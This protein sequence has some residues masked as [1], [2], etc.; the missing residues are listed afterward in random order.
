MNATASTNASTIDQVVSQMGG[1]RTEL[2]KNWAAPG[3]IWLRPTTKDEQSNDKTIGEKKLVSKA[4][5]PNYDP[6]IGTELV[7]EDSVNRANPP[8]T[9]GK[10]PTKKPDDHRMIGA[11]TALAMILGYGG[12]KVVPQ[13]VPETQ[14]TSSITYEG[15]W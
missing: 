6:A 9:Y 13:N 2:P 8:S 12:Y 5:A 3:L 4:S 15:V 1:R 10:V 14:V 7:L 11:V